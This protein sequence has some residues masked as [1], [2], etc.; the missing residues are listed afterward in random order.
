MHDDVV[1]RIQPL[2]LELVGDDRHRAVRL[3]AHDA[4]AAVLARELPA[5]VV[6]RVAVAVAGRIAERRDAAV[7]FDPAHLDVVRNVAPHQIAPDAVPG[8]PFGPQRADVQPPDDGVADD[9]AAEPIV[10]RDDVGIGILNRI[11][12]RPV[13]CR[14]VLGETCGCCSPAAATPMAPL[15][16]AR[17]FIDASLFVFVI[18]FH[19]PRTRTP[20]VSNAFQRGDLTRL[21]APGIQ[22]RSSTHGLHTEAFM[23]SVV[24]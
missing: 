13:P 19:L 10:E 9:V 15:K 16:N 7:V 11:L 20:H 2:A 23:L 14:L 6:E 18:T 12:S 4:A 24:E 8:R 17:R 5:F 21:R 3:V 1:R 22:Q